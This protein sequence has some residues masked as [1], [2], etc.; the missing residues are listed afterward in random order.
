MSRRVGNN[1]SV[2]NGEVSPQEFVLQEPASSCVVGI[3][4]AQGNL[5]QQLDYGSLDAGTQALTWDGKDYSGQQVA[6][7]VYT[8][9]V[10]AET[11][12]GDAVNVE[13]HTRGTV[14]GVQFN[15]GQ[16]QVTLDG[17]IPIQVSDIV[18]VINQQ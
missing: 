4:D 1:L 18:N 13:S 17:N 9:K 14:T 6:D 2:K 10:D 5:V 8:Y 11:A 3:Y 16:A 15:N 7:G 12:L